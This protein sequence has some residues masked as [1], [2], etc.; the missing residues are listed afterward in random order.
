MKNIADAAW[1]QGKR[2]PVAVEIDDD[3]SDFL[4]E[5]SFF[6]VSGLVLY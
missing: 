4:Q 6:A 2:R 5:L 1:K 3:I